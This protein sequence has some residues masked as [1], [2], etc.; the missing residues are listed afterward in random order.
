MKRQ[1]SPCAARTGNSF[2]AFRAWQHGE[3]ALERASVQ[4]TLRKTRGKSSFALGRS[5]HSRSGWRRSRINRNE[6][7]SKKSSRRKRGAF[8]RASTRQSAQGRGS[9]ALR[10]CSLASK[11][12]L[13]YCRYESPEHGRCRVFV[14]GKDFE[15]EGVDS[16]AG[17]FVVQEP[18]D[19]S[20]APASRRA[21]LVRVEPGW[22]GNVVDPLRDKN[23]I[24]AA[25]R[26]VLLWLGSEEFAADFQEELI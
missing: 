9:L 25:R 7:G 4:A 23:L 15:V 6:S 21:D 18:G 20:V 10:P 13:E 8:A 26:I 1:S 14:I 3:N 17:C 12:S 16:H 22:T 24:K 19:G 11:D 5:S 2:A